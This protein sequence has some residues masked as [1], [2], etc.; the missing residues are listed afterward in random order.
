MKK[1]KSGVNKTLKKLKTIPFPNKQSPNICGADVEYLI[2]SLLECGV[3]SLYYHFTPYAS[4]CYIQPGYYFNIEN[5]P[6]IQSVIHGTLLADIVGDGICEGYQD[7]LPY[8][9]LPYECFEEL[10]GSNLQSISTRK[11]YKRQSLPSWTEAESCQDQETSA[12][13]KRK[14]VKENNVTSTIVDLT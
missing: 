11:D 5:F 13:R 3:L 4:L 7:I 14:K 1:I 6:N 2:A 12:K 9:L 8:H 10:R